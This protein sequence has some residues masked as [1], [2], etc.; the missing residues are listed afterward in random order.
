MEQ[1][2]VVAA[3]GLASCRVITPVAPPPSA[4]AGSFLPTT[5]REAPLRVENMRVQSPETI[6]TS[7]DWQALPCEMVSSTPVCAH[8]GNGPPS[9]IFDTAQDN[10]ISLEL[11]PNLNRSLSPFG[12]VCKK[13]LRELQTS[14]INTSSLSN[15]EIGTD[16]RG[17]LPSWSANSSKDNVGDSQDSV[18]RTTVG[19]S[20]TA[21]ARPLSIQWQ[22][23]PEDSQL[24]DATMVNQLLADRHLGDLGNLGEWSVQPGSISADTTVAATDDATTSLRASEV[25]YLL[26]SWLSDIKSLFQLGRMGYRRGPHL[27]IGENPVICR[28]AMRV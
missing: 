10:S 11:D 15:T 13:E 28:R 18:S 5:T 23:V 17:P 21:F 1:T 8:N 4:G 9:D 22:P 16:G 3:T 26:I 7:C 19:D 2:S 14:T 12:P 20:S 6:E 24:Q 25:P 27:V